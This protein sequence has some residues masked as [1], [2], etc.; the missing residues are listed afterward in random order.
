[1]SNLG[2]LIYHHHPNK[3]SKKIH[4]LLSYK[5]LVKEKPI[6]WNL[7]A[8]NVGFLWGERWLLGFELQALWF[9]SSEIQIVGRNVNGTDNNLEK[10][11]QQFA[12]DP[13]SYTEG[14]FAN[15]GI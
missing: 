14:A 4:S 5:K 13:S 8:A 3:Q 2:L 7:K 9:L 1:V 11:S 6:F 15:I 10:E 12:S